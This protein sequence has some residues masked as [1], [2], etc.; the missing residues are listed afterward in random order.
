MQCDRVKFA[1]ENMLLVRT[2][3]RTMFIRRFKTMETERTWWLTLQLTLVPTLSGWSLVVTVYHHLHFMSQPVQLVMPTKSK[4]L[5]SGLAWL[6]LFVKCTLRI[7][8]TLVLESWHKWSND[9]SVKSLM[10][11]KQGDG[12]PFTDLSLLF[13]WREGYSACRNL[14]FNPKMRNWGKQ[15]NAGS[16]WKWPLKQ[17]T[18]SVISIMLFCFIC[19]I[20][21]DLMLANK[22]LTY[23]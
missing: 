14:P 20:S 5:V 12:V 15:V 17:P 2:H 21:L 16:S 7:R 18:N 10:M 13:W 4:F 22:L 8:W 1:D 6:S 23:I 11:M 9:T 3:K 19:F